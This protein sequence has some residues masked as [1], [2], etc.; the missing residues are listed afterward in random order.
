[1]ASLINPDG[2]PHQVLNLLSRYPHVRLSLHGHVHA[3][4]LTTHGGIAFVTTSSA[5]EYPMQWREVIVRE[6]EI[7]MRTRALPV[8]SDTLAMS[9]RRETGRGDPDERNRAKVGGALENHLL[10]SVCTPAEW[11]QRENAPRPRRRLARRRER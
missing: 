3:N 5:S 7:E 4:S 2:L 11:E 9:R 8:P 6:C 1:M 10:L